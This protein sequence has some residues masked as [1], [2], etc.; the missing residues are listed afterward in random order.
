MQPSRVALIT[1]SGKRRVG[2][3]VAQTLAQ[4]GFSLAI[5]FHR[6]SADAQE[7][8][9][10]FRRR[11]VDAEAFGADLADEQA[12]QAMIAEVIARFGRVD[13]LVNCAAIWRSKP[14]EE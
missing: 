10:D 12:V 5:H 14:L 1:G 8:V 4:H 2:W 6:S 11:N 3:Y 7:T 9:A 13:V